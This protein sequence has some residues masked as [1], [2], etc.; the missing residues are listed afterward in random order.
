MRLAV[1]VSTRGTNL[2]YL[3][4][5]IES[6]RLVDIELVLVVS[7]KKDCLAVKWA[8]EKCIKNL[9]FEKKVNESDVDFDCKIIN[10]LKKENV[11]LV[12][13]IGYM[14]ILSNYFISEF[15]NKIINCHPSIL[16]AFAGG[17]N[18]N[19]FKEVLQKGYKITGDTVHFVDENLDAGPVIMQKSVVVDFDDN[20]ESLKN[21]VQKIEGKMIVQCIEFFRDNKLIVHDDGRVQIL[22]YKGH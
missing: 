10:A 2:K 13:L 8:K 7:N 1:L 22:D 12:F 14:K 4:N 5:E 6:G 20:I 18:I 11:D 9:C 16:P 15:R 17:M 21:K 3:Y 19:V